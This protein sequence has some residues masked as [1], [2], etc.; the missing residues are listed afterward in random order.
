[1]TK[2]LNF[3][4]LNLDKVYSVEK[5]VREGETISA[6]EMNT[7]PGGKGLNQSIA[8][9]RAGAEV[10]MAGGLGFDAGLLESTLAEAQVKTELLE[11]R[12]KES[13]HAI[14]QV[15]AN[16]KNCIV[17][18][19]GSNHGNTL[20]YI[21]SVMSKFSKG[22]ILLL[23]NE[24]DAN[25]L[26]IA[27]AKKI[28]LIITLNPSPL[29]KRVLALDLADIDI[30]LL[31]EHEAAG[32]LENVG[33]TLNLNNTL[34]DDKIF[35]SILQKLHELY[36]RLTVV[37][38]LGSEGSM[39]INQHG[40]VFR[41]AAY[42]NKVVDTTAAGDTFTG[43]FIAAMLEQEDYQRALK[44]ASIAAGLAVGKAGAAPSIPLREELINL[45]C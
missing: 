33:I 28:G 1:M 25:E 13:G 5:I 37:L 27:E 2:V 17:I 36:P 24:I 14:I 7:Y 16:G 22:D 30:L 21:E 41:Q 35:H 18:Y 19:P 26:I 29:N 43:Y 12:E 15:D 45:Q 10:Y 32:L 42:K 8:L 11:R 40:E 20:K 9:A 44:I 34:A 23:Q 31:N 6:L 39:L 4:S 3:G 38:T